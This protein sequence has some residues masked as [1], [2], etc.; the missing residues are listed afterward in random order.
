MSEKILVTGASGR[1]GLS[2]CQALAANREVWAAARFTEPSARARLES[3]GAR[4]VAVDVGGDL[5][6]LP[7]DFTGVVHLAAY[8]GGGHDFDLAMSINAEASGLV[9]HH[10]RMARAFLHVSAAAVY[11]PPPDPW[12]LIKETDALQPIPRA[13][14]Q[15]YAVTKLAAEGVVRTMARVLGL[16]TTIARLNVAYGASG[17][18]P[19]DHLEAIR[20]GSPI[21]VGELPVVRSPISHDDMALQVPAL[22]DAAS[23]PA[24]IV[25]WGGD[26]AVSKQQWC[27]LLGG[28]IDRP[29]VFDPNGTEPSAAMDPRKRLAITGPCTVPWDEGMRL[30]TGASAS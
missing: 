24:T 20:A 30:L 5:S 14:S 4:T 17:G 6:V 29:V 10:C 11:A 2:I 13:Y 8:I 19:M 16:P 27:T 3:V 26:E 28:L 23:V 25:N 22:L 15:T 12:Y 18:Q 21:R 9:M 7:E 1:T